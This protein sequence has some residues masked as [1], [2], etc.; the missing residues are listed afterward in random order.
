MVG[1][2]GIYIS[3]PFHDARAIRNLH[4]IRF[5]E[6]QR[7]RCSSIAQARPDVNFEQ[8]EHIDVAF[9]SFG[10]NSVFTNLHAY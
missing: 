6:I 10:I 1:I 3:F 5:R 2:I 7:A 4:D 9:W 8:N